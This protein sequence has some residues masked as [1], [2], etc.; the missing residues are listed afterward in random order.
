[1]TPGVTASLRDVVAQVHGRVVLNRVPSFGITDHDSLVG[2]LGY[3]RR[4]IILSG[5]NDRL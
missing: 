3:F 1:M 5:Q 4:P 2:I